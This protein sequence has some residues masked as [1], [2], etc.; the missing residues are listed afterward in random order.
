MSLR[1]TLVELQYMQGNFHFLGFEKAM[2]SWSIPISSDGSIAD[3]P[4][5]DKYLLNLFPA[6]SYTPHFPILPCRVELHILT[7]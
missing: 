5:E 7:W 4:K 6:L 3:R 2:L 1:D